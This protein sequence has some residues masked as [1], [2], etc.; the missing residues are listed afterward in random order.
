MKL[1]PFCRT[2]IGYKICKN[3]SLTLTSTRD[4]SLGMRS[5]KSG[6]AKYYF[7]RVMGAMSS[8][9]RRGSQN[10]FCSLNVIRAIVFFVR[11]DLYYVYTGTTVPGQHCMVVRTVLSN[12]A[13]PCLHCKNVTVPRAIMILIMRQRLPRN[14]SSESSRSQLSWRRID[15]V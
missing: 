6:N 12:R 4:T 11:S 5:K 1:I 7:P 3:G 8:S 2:G 13:G 9:Q 14:A 15:P 10:L